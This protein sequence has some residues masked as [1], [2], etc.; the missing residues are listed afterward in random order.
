LIEQWYSEAFEAKQQQQQQQYLEDVVQELDQ[1]AQQGNINL[2]KKGGQQE[3]V[4]RVLCFV[5]MMGVNMQRLF[6]R[7]CVLLS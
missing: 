5:R 3:L 1:A 7:K 2:S 6:L 4:D